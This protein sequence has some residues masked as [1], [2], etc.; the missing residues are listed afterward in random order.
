[1]LSWFPRSC[2]Y[3][4]GITQN[5]TPAWVHLSQ[6]TWTPAPCRKSPLLVLHASLI[7][8]HHLKQYR[9]RCSDLT[10][11][12]ASQA[13]SVTALCFKLCTCV[14]P[15]TQA[16]NPQH[17]FLQSATLLLTLIKV[18][19]HRLYLISPPPPPP[20]SAFFFSYK[21][22]MLKSS[23][24]RKSKRKKPPRPPFLPPTQI[25]LLTRVSTHRL[26]SVIIQ[27]T[28]RHCKHAI[29]NRPRRPRP[30]EAV[31][32][33]WRTK[34]KLRLKQDGVVLNKQRN[35]C[36][37]TVLNAII[38]AQLQG[39]LKQSSQ[40]F[41]SLPATCMSSVEFHPWKCFE[42]KKNEKKRQ[43]VSKI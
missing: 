20:F 41:F 19:L 14:C 39:I 16:S 35:L 7:M 21:A 4:A 10:L 18:H 31:Q 43:T 22:C 25:K 11:C 34:P 27:E 3:S 2:F 8:K 32:L 33:I 12:L 9:R 5:L 28:S 40:T 1:M 24:E 13:H 37:F 42:L 30:L 36:C 38:T 26:H 29:F 6:F 23:Q 17:K 15:V